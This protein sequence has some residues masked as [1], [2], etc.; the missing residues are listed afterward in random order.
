MA[1]NKRPSVD[2]KEGSKII[3][4][5]FGKA[6]AN[7]MGFRASAKDVQGKETHVEIW[8]TSKRDVSSWTR[9]LAVRMENTR[10]V[11]EKFL[12]KPKKK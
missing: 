6:P 1:G 12:N 5:V 11:Y 2:F 8:Q 3:R 7:Y 4:T 10:H 9:A